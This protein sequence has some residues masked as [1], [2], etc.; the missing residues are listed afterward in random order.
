[1]SLNYLGDDNRWSS[2]LSD[3]GIDSGNGLLCIDDGKISVI[4]YASIEQVLESKITE[5]ILNPDNTSAV[6]T[7]DLVPLLKN[8]DISK[9]NG[10]VGKQLTEKISFGS[11]SAQF[12]L[13]G[14][15]QDT[16]SGANTGNILTFISEAYLGTSKMAPSATNS[17]GYNS[18]ATTMKSYLTTQY[19]GMNSAWK[20]LVLPVT[21]E[22]GTSKTAKST[23]T[24]QTLWIP[25]MYEVALSNTSSYEPNC[26]TTY[27]YFSGESA[28]GASD[29]RKR[30]S[31]DNPTSFNDWWLRSGYF[32]YTNYFARVSSDGS[33]NGGLANGTFGVVLGFCC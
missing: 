31:W 26:G 6:I 8:T 18:A 7:S 11:M 10:I 24:N 12:R 23:M 19:N 14:I 33:L 4:P 29:K 5:D 13:V 17:G 21:K 1:M 15:N 3:F 25:S 30:G 32:N 16:A 27:T 20:A 28:T 9:L 22:Y 2:P